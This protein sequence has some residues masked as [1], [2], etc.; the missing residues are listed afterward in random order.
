MPPPRRAWPGSSPAC[1]PR[2]ARWSRQGRDRRCVLRAARVTLAG[3]MMPALTSHGLAGEP[4]RGRCLPSRPPAE[5]TVTAPFRPGGVVR[6]S[7]GHRGGEQLPRDAGADRLVAGQ[8]VDDD[9]HRAAARTRAVPPPRPRPPRSPRR[10]A[11]TASS[12]RLLLLL[13]LDLSGRADLDHRDAAGQ[14]G[15]PLLELLAVPVA[16]DLLDLGLDLVDPP[17]TSDFSPAPSTIVVS[18]LVTDDRLAR[19]QISVTFSA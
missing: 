6:R 18:S 3:S 11:D 9:L 12:M 1:R 2:G 19:P 4:R 15:Q 16:V 13:Q 10:V 8:A 7:A 5:R 14:L 17:W